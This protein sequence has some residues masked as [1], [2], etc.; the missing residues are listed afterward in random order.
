MPFQSLSNFGKTMSFSFFPKLMVFS[1]L[2]FSVFLSF[3]WGLYAQ[4]LLVQQGEATVP[5]LNENSD[6]ASKNAVEAA[7]KNIIEFLL[8][9]FISQQTLLFKQELIAETILNNPDRFIE[10]TRIISS[11]ESD[12]LSE[13]TLVLEAKVFAF[14]LKAALKRQNLAL[15]TD[16]LRKVSLLY[17]PRESLWDTS[18]GQYV[19]LSLNQYLSP[20]RIQIQHL[21]PLNPEWLN[22]LEI[23]S[24]QP[25]P[26]QVLSVT[27]TNAYLFFDW[28]PNVITE[29]EAGVEVK[30]GLTVRLYDSHEGKRIDQIQMTQNFANWDANFGFLE[31]IEQLSQN[32]DALIGQLIESDKQKGRFIQIEIYGLTL[33]AH[34]AQFVQTLLTSNP[35]WDQ[36][37]LAG[38]MKDHVIFRG[39]FSG[40]IQQ[41]VDDL[42]KRNV[43]SFTIQQIV[44][45]EN[46]LEFYVKWSKP[47][48]VLEPYRSNNVV[49]SAIETL[50]LPEPRLQVPT[51][52]IKSI[53][54]LPKPSTVYDFVRSR[55]DSTMYQIN[56][57][58][59][60]ARV[61]IAFNL[62]DKTN[63]QPIIS[64]YNQEMVL[65]NRHP[66]SRNGKIRFVAQ[67]SPQ[68]SHFFIRVSD[69]T[70]VIEG[71]SGSFLSFH[72]LLEVK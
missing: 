15:L 7:K 5:I 21:I 47:P 20:Y 30:V 23:N 4:E 44:G 43:P 32:W 41:F 62:L 22:A 31:M 38:Y 66:V 19:I 6:E 46:R 26:P 34:E 51:Q 17:D 72:Y 25:I 49:E 18:L 61:S 1:L 42:K 16:P 14:P 35:Q 3:S 29:P 59:G 55:G 56:R 8:P 65:I 13:L 71:E 52:R 70:G 12:D 39:F 40:D 63:L 67:F 10:S 50:D 36:V 68:Q 11:E 57:G 24:G 33:P 54:H 53:Y 28:T 69:Q 2:A 64:V 27:K 58:P 45:S 9:Q 48:T 37:Q 60:N